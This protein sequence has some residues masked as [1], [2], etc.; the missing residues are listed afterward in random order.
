LKEAERQKIEKSKEQI[1]IENLQKARDAK[2]AGEPLMHFILKLSE[3]LFVQTQKKKPR[4][5]LPPPLHRKEAPKPTRRRR[6][7]KQ[8]M[9]NL[10]NNIHANKF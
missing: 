9:V 2:K 10:S 5:L 3:S 1:K 7:R 8:Q 6:A 4:P